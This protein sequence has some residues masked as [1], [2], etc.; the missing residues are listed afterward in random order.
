M[1]VRADRP[2]LILL[3]VRVA[4]LLGWLLVSAPLH[5]ATLLIL[6]RSGWPR[7]F[8]AGV[9]RI[10][11][12]RVTVTGEPARAPTLLVSNHR[13]WLDIPVLA[14]ATGCAFVAKDGLRGH[15]L[16]RWLCEQN[17]TLFVDRS[18]RQGVS[19][20]ADQVR[21]ALGRGRPLILFAEGTVSP[22]E[23]L[24]PFRPPLLAAV[25]P[26]PNGVAVR[27]VAVGY[28]EAQASLAWRAGE[29]GVANFRKVMGRRGKLNAMVQLLAPLPK[30]PD[31]KV[32]AKAAQAAVESALALSKSSALPYM[33]KPS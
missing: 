12:V 15:W 33:G 25:A 1:T 2:S 30:S 8:L 27:P 3:I 31:R 21:Q 16:M 24:L 28:G 20:Q 19:A 5:L 10:A 4:A 26:A 22:E 11:G 14:A 29:S 6:G 9:A 23:G 17:G 18:D 13:S 32:L 7:R